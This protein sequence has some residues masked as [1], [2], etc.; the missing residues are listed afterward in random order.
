MK[1]GRA[2]TARSLQ[3]KLHYLC[4]VCMNGNR[5]QARK[6]AG[7]P[8]SVMRRRTASTELR[9]PFRYRPKSPPSTKSML[10]GIQPGSARIR[11]TDSI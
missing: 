8:E 9:Q 11:L 3:Q 4:V 7:A 5:R 1:A 10:A 2:E 6:A